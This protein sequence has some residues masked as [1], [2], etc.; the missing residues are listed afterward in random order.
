MLTIIRRNYEDLIAK[1]HGFR[2]VKNALVFTNNILNS[3]FHA[4][5]KIKQDDRSLF[6][7]G[8]YQNCCRY[9]SIE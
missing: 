8:H 2:Y 9:V 7:K 4:L 6:V 5:S 1:T 3:K